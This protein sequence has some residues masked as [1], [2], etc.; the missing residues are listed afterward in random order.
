ML[1]QHA[2]SIIMYT[3]N[4][5]KMKICQEHMTQLSLLFGLVHS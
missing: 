4:Q 3:E 1:P 5:R 2:K